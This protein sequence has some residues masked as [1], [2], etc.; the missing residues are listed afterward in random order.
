MMN[1]IRVAITHGDTNSIGYRL[2]FKAFETDDLYDS[3]VPIVYGS[4]KVAAYHRKYL[5]SSTNFSIIQQAGDAQVSRLNLL[6]AFDDDVKVTIGEPNKDSARAAF[7]ALNKAL[8]DYT[9]QAYDVLV[10]M[11]V[12]QALMQ[13]IDSAYTGEMDYISMHLNFK[14]VSRLFVTDNIRLMLVSENTRLC[15]VPEDITVEHILSKARLLH[16]TL[17]R[18]FRISNPRIALLSVNVCPQQEEAET[19]RPAIEKLAEEKIQCFGP[20]NADA[21]FSQKMYEN[22]DATLAMY[23]DQAVPQM[24]MSSDE[25]VV[26]TIGMPLIHCSL[27]QTRDPKSENLKALYLALDTFRNRNSYDEAHQNPLPKLYHEHREG[28]ERRPPR[29]ST[30]D[31][32]NKDKAPKGEKGT[33]D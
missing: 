12:E 21:F 14:D 22:F 17:M 3:F 15:D 13:E 29:F 30:L 5:E 18:D 7:R 20:Y 4:P 9:Q 24:L 28:E 33:E 2:I 1:K 26:M 10:T 19:I 16:T 6:A 31:F 25:C 32:L 27:L 8:D 11:P 23:Y